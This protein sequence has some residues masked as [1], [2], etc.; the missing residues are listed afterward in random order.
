MEKDI[1]V[2]EQVVRKENKSRNDY[3]L[4]GDWTQA[5][6]EVGSFVGI[7]TNANIQNVEA[8]G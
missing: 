4:A 3:D 2:N 5:G 8:F 1:V 6:D 7:G